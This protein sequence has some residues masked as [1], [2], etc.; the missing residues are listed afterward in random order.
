VTDEVNKMLG[1]KGRYRHPFGR[2][3]SKTGVAKAGKYL[4]IFPGAGGG[5]SGYV[6]GF[7]PLAKQAN[8][9][10]EHLFENKIVRGV[11]L[12]IGTYYTAGALSSA[13]SGTAVA[14]A[15]AASTLGTEAGSNIPAFTSQ[16]GITGSTGTSGT[17]F[18][19]TALNTAAP[20]AGSNVPAFTAQGGASTSYFGTEAAVSNVPAFTA[21][22]T[23]SGSYFGAESMA[24]NVPAA[25]E[26]GLLDKLVAAAKYTGEVAAG[27]LATQT[28]AKLLAPKQV[29]SE[30]GYYDG[31]EPPV[32]VMGGGGGGG[33]TGGDGG[34]LFGDDGSGSGSSSWAGVALGLIAAAAIVVLILQGVRK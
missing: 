25:S 27:T 33:P 17:F 19:E 31:G 23:A 6:P 18:G 13:F 11:G 26:P 21:E 29:A 8:T 4:A 10:S 9:N 32:I 12:A 5:D 28:V 3:F 24:G 34:G 14:E 1:G 30:G 20:A 22:G 15:G 16:G 7:L 2:G